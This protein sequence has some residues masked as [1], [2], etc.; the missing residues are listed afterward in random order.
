MQIILKILE[1]AEEAEV[2]TRKLEEAEVHTEKYLKKL[3]KL[4]KLKFILKA[5]VHTE[6]A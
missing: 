5:E 4:K 6:E 1:E 2:H 3:K